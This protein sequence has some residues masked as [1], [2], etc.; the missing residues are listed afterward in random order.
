MDSQAFSL[1]SVETK[2]EHSKALSVEVQQCHFS[3]I[4]LRWRM[5]HRKFVSAENIQCTGNTQI[6]SFC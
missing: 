3:F 5:G 2:N 4:S 6:Y 1:T